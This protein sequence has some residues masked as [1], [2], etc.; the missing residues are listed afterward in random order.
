MS[1]RAEHFG[2]A[3]RDRQ[4]DGVAR[5]HVGDRDAG[6]AGCW[7]DRG[8]S[9]SSVSAEPPMLRRSTLTVLCAT[10]PSALRDARRRRR[11]RTCGA[12]RSARSAR[13]RRSPARA[14][15][16]ARRRNPCRR[17]PA[18]RRACC[19]CVHAISAR[20]R[21]PTAACAAASGSAPAGGRR[22][23]SRRVRAARAAL[24]R[25]EQHVAALGRG[26][27]RAT[28]VARPV[29]IGAVADHELDLVVR[30]QQRQVLQQVAR[31]FAASP[32][33]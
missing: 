1:L 18:R 13:A 30:R 17:R 26:G 3:Q 8:T 10:A 27:A 11:V 15:S 19:A 2:P 14:R 29:V 9:M 5:R 24:A 22:R 31:D 7:S 21:R 23:S 16:R 25:R 20:A 4:H 12:G 32:A 33:S 6:A 28:H